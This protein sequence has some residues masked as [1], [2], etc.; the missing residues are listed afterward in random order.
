MNKNDV[1]KMYRQGHTID[2][3]AYK[4]YY[5]NRHKL[6]PAKFTKRD[7]RSIVEQ[8][9]YDYIMKAKFGKGSAAPAQISLGNF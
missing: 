5:S 3:L 2:D 1:V 4:Y 8:I 9:I 6:L 7:S